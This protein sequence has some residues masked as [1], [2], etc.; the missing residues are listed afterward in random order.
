[1]KEIAVILGVETVTTLT[2]GF[3]PARPKA[4]SR[5]LARLTPAELMALDA[6]VARLS[7]E[8][9]PEEVKRV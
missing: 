6:E 7:K 5:I 1:M 8:G 4:C 2:D 3:F 9:N